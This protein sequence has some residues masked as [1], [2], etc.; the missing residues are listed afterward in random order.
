[1]SNLVKNSISYIFIGFLPIAA[2]FFLAPVYAHYLIP[3]QYAIIGVATLFQTFLTFF[4]SLSLDGAY[5]RL[6]FTYE[7]KS[8]LSDA[9]LS[10]LLI[11]IIAVSCLVT[12]LLYFWGDFILGVSFKNNEFKFSDLG[13]WVLIT[14][15]CN[16]IFSLF[17]ILYRNQENIKAFIRL[18]ILFFFIP[19]AGILTGL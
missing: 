2:N 12:L 17:A 6:Y 18:S 8:K 5:N 14:T 15:L 13:Y 3:E 1:M 19:V 4:L 7:R 10:T 16:I 11:T 9:L